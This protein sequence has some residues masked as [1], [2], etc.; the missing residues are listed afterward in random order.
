MRMGRNTKMLWETA[1]L[2]MLTRYW[3]RGTPPKT[4]L[5]VG[6][7]IASLA[8]STLLCARHVTEGSLRF[9]VDCDMMVVW[10]RDKEREKAHERRA[11]ETS[12]ERR[13]RIAEWNKEV[14]E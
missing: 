9:Y 4:D 11:R 10:D 1:P 12:T 8:P 14:K 13:A 3:E 5:E 7:T 6:D 2:C